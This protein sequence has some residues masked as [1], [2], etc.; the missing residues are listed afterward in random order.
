MQCTGTRPHL[1]ARGKSHGF[2]GLAAGTWGIFLNFRGDGHL[3]LE[4]VQRS[5][6]SYV[7]MMDNS[8]I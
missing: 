8:G 1:T 6:D 2:Y 3:K 4:F 5:H 7:V